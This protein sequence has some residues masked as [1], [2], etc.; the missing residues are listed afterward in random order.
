M[1]KIGL[2]DECANVCQWS[3]EDCKD[4]ASAIFACQNRN[5]GREDGYYTHWLD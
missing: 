1:W 2:I 5:K 4:E 3:I